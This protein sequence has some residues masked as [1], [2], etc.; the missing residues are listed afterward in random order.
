MRYFWALPFVVAIACTQTEPMDRDS[1]LSVSP[2]GDMFGDPASDG[3]TSGDGGGMGDGGTKA[4][5]GG[6]GD[7]GTGDGGM[8]PLPTGWCSAD[9]WCWQNPLPHGNHLFGVRAFSKSEAWAAGNSGTIQRWDGR[10]WSKVPTSGSGQFSKMAASASDDIWLSA[11]PDFY[12]WDGLSWSPVSWRPEI[13]GTISNQSAQVHYALNKNDAWASGS[14]FKTTGETEYFVLRWDG[15]KW[16]TLST[17]KDMPWG[18]IWASSASDAWSLGLPGTIYHWDGSAWSSVSSGTTEYLTAIWGTGTNDVWAVGANGAIV[19][20]N[21]ALWSA[22]SS[23][24]TERLTDVW[25]VGARDVWATGFGGTVLHYDGTAWKGASSGTQERLT[26]V[27]GSA[28]DDVWIVGLAGLVLHWD[29]ARLTRI[30]GIIPAPLTKSPDLRDLWGTSPTDVWAVGDEGAALHYDGMRWTAPPT[31]AKAKLNA[32]WGSAAD[33]VWA[34]GDAGTILRWDRLRW[35]SFASATMNNLTGVHG[36]GSA[37]VW[38][39]GTTLHRWNGTAWF[40]VSNGGLGAATDVRVYS[41]TNVWAVGDT[42]RWWDGAKWTQ[43]LGVGGSKIWG[44]GPGDIW[45]GPG[46]IFRWDG[47]KFVNKTSG[48]NAIDIWI[49]GVDTYWG[50]GT[51]G[52]IDGTNAGDSG[53]SNSLYGIWRNVS[54]RDTWVVGDGGTILYRDGRTIP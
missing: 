18:A 15:T 21:G 35:T 17:A 10:V 26:A 50:T 39:A 22:S 37:E 16:K 48:S 2:S 31:G 52:N 8:V 36:I 6:M 32:V 29:G 42:V 47:S 33:N 41:A 24:T 4:D 9:R 1:D 7:G 12:H 44:S 53:T 30:G 23:G 46:N 13:I 43:V 45:I 14:A 51:S 38:A 5:G 3:G 25:G 20:W 11:R 28:A 27:S 34:V 40:Q 49:T 19:H 54:T